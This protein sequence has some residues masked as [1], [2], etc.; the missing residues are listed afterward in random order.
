MQRGGEE[1]DG[2]GG[3]QTLT[4]LTHVMD[5][6]DG[7]PAGGAGAVEGDVDHAVRGLDAVLLEGEKHLLHNLDIEHSY[8]P[9]R[10]KYEDE[11]N[12][13]LRKNV[14]IS[15]DSKQT[16]LPL[17]QQ[18]PGS[19]LSILEK[20]SINEFHVTVTITVVPRIVQQRSVVKQLCA[21]S[22]KKKK[23]K[24]KEQVLPLGFDVKQI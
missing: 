9:V 8:P 3:E 21:A 1:G 22:S 5:R 17:I 11:M 20:I 16:H 10:Q 14:K 23:G 4:L 12:Q 24:K 7:G 18:Y 6:Q 13:N 19:Q 2:D 15:T